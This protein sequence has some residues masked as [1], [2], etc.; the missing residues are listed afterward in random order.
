MA[1]GAARGRNPYLAL[2][3]S[4]VRSQLAYRSSFA[5][6]VLGDV[7]FGLAELATVYVVFAHVQ[8]LGGLTAWQ[9]GL[10]FAV[11]N[12]GFAV[13]D[14]LT[15][16]VDHLPQFLRTGEL[17]AFLLRPAPVLAQLLTCDV[18][19][20]RVGRAGLALAVLLVVLP[21]AG[22][23]WTVGRALLLASAPLTGAAVFAALFVLAGAL[24]FWLV[25]GREVVNSFTY[26]GG[27]AAQF[28]AS[29][30]G[31]GLRVLFTYVV[32]AAAT[33]YLPVLAVLGEPGPAWTPAWLG[34]CG[35]LF[36][37]AS[38]AVALLVWRAGLRRYTGAGS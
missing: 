34:W 20:R 16:H 25:E 29:A 9:A 14:L 13:A 38:W 26:G 35:P 33:A 21:R 24:Q 32:P 23:D 30:Y 10:V 36:A 3:G 2:V 12:L 18:S 5:V 37:A 17:D 8:A 6:S 27:F 28:P 15:G 1:E 19:L 22:V 7:G 4:R 31:S 11:A